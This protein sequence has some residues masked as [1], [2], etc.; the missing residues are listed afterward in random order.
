MLEPMFNFSAVCTTAF[1]TPGNLAEALQA[2]MNSS[3][4]ARP[5]AFVKGVRVKT[6]HL[7]YKKTV[8]TVTNLKPRQHKFTSEDMGEIDVETYFRRSPLFTSSS[9]LF[10]E[11]YLLQNT[12][13]L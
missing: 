11:D 6:L 5:A 12:I 4:G 13:S 9:L 8:K 3:F 2:F 1:Y 7:G 10:A